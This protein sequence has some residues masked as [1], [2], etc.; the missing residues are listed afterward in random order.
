MEKLAMT[1]KSGEPITT[2]M[3]CE[4]KVRD[5]QDVAEV[6]GYPL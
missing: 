4:A 1:G 6:S 3:A 2:S 5:H